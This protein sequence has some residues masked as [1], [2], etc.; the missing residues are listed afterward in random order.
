VLLS[1]LRDVPDLYRETARLL[2]QIPRGRV[3]TY[4]DVA[5]ALGDARAARWVG[6]FLLS[7]VHGDDCPCHRVVRV[8]GDVGLY[9]TR[10][11]AEKTSRLEQDGVAVVQGRVDLGRVRF[12]GFRSSAPLAV[13]R[14]LQAR[15]PA[16]LRLQPLPHTPQRV[17][18]VDVSYLSSTEA[19]AAFVL[20]ELPSLELLG[21]KTLRGEVAFPYI[22]GYLAFRELPL[23]AKL[24]D[25][26]RAAGYEPDVTFV[27]G[28]GILHPRRAGI[29]SCFGL[30]AG[31]PTIGVGKTLL[32]GRID[33]GSL[34]HAHAQALVH[35]GETIGYTVRASP[36]NRPFYVSP[37]HLTDLAAALAVTRMTL[38]QHRLPLP[39]TFADRESRSE[40]QRIANQA[41]TTSPLPG[42]GDAHTERGHSTFSA[43][44]RRIPGG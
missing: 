8:N 38:G 34:A 15:I 12:D 24:F 20:L 6:E 2:R 37:G 21:T 27:D 30:A 10:C 5:R 17:G 39:I 33:E 9:I 13:L 44:E 16:Q 41:C 29:A 31:T 18:G 42:K 35:E 4:G 43:L 23:L 1:S 28:N 26:V 7:H 11:E 3:T 40:A 36:K 25:K 14:E 19:V 22:S 32:C